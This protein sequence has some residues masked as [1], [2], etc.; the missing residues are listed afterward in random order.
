MNSIV[1]TSSSIRIEVTEEF[2]NHESYHELPLQKFKE[3]EDCA[4]QVKIYFH[5]YRNEPPGFLLKKRFPRQRRDPDLSFI[6]EGNEKRFVIDQHYLDD[7]TDFIYDY[8][9]IRFDQLRPNAINNGKFVVIVTAN[10]RMPICRPMLSSYTSN[11]TATSLNFKQFANTVPD[12]KFLLDG[13][14]IPVHKEYMS[15][16]SPVFKAMFSHDTKETRT[17]TIEITD[18]DY[19]T[20]KAAVDLL[21]GHAFESKSLPEVILML[22]FCEKYFITSAVNQL[23]G[24][25]LNNTTVDELNKYQKL[26]ALLQQMVL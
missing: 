8:E 17:G 14:C 19:D 2:L 13:K 3:V 23:K 15:N 26:E 12:F 20:V 25:L 5:N 9:R 22:R 7:D 18:F 11:T 10:V 6:I 24:W 1:K 16:I 4:W 21:Y